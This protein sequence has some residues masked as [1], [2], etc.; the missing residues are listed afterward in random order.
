M[1]WGPLVALAW[2]VILIG[3]FL[4]RTTTMS[5]LGFQGYVRGQAAIMAEPIA[6]AIVSDSLRVH[7][8][9]H[10]RRSR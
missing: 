7:R 1:R 8:E 4:W 6:R 2:G 10:A 3:G 9:R 5:A